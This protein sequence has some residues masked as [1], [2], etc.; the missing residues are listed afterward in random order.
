MPGM[1]E[2]RR[3]EDGRSAGLTSSPD[4]FLTMTG[5]ERWSE[6][7]SLSSVEGDLGFVSHT[8][9]PSVEDLE[10][11]IF[12]ACRESGGV[13]LNRCLLAWSAWLV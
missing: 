5:R 10:C 1:L 6:S 9:E 2:K 13:D 7:F 3:H 12:R 11:E 4:F 8:I